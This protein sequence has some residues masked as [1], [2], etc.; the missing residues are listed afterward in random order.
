MRWVTAMA[1]VVVMR[2]RQGQG[3]SGEGRMAI[4]AIRARCGW[5]GPG[6]A[7][8]GV[9][10]GS[11]QTKQAAAHSL[12]GSLGEKGKKMTKAHDLSVLAVCACPQGLVNFIQAF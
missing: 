5:A 3:K 1:M 6:R 10:F 2:V 9:G 11:R 8:C 12:W 7:I 4:R